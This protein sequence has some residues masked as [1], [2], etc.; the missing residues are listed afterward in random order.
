MIRKT[1]EA[2]IAIIKSFESLHDGD[3]SVIGLQPKMDPVGIWTEGWGHAIVYKGEFLKGKENKE[4]A[5]QLAKIK[6]KEEA[7]ELLSVD[8]KPRESFVNEFVSTTVTQ[9]QFD[10]MVSLV[11]NIGTGNFSTSS[12][13]RY[14]NL[15]QFDKAANSFK[16]FNKAGGKVL[17]GLTRRRKAEATLYSKPN[18]ISKDLAWIDQFTKPRPID[19]LK[20]LFYAIRV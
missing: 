7:D 17:V 9:N 14:T 19:K 15:K 18:D 8:L 4:L 12:V 6:T 2:G 20:W 3:L 1:G 16:L 10:A 11:Y 5:Y 13:L